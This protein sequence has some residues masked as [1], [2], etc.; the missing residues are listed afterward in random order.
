MYNKSKLEAKSKIN[1][2]DTYSV[3]VVTVAK[4][5]V[6]KTLEQIGTIM[7]SNDVSVVAEASG[8]VTGI[9]TK[10]GD[11]K[12][13]GS[14]IIQLDDELKYAAYLTAEV[15]YQ[16]AKNDFERYEYLYKEGTIPATR[17]DA[18]KLELQS[19]E[20]QYIF[21]KR[22]YTNTKITAPISGVITARN[23]DEGDYVNQGTVVANIVDISKLKVELN[24]AEKDAFKLKPGDEVEIFTDVYPGITYKGKIES[25]SSK[26]DA[27]HT[28]PLEITLPNNTKNPLK[29]GMFG[30]VSFTS[31]KNDKALLIPRAALVGSVRD[32]KVFVVENG[33]AKEKNI[34][35][36]NVYDDLLEVLQGLNPGEK[37]V[38]NGQ[39]NLKNNY[40]VKVIE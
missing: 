10:V 18:V 15:N 4:K 6:S 37:V 17:F 30:R 13:K 28:Y 1:V 26:G 3:N 11:N 23:V 16:K 29:A 39:N 22:E 12:S 40:A 7:G 34:L 33:I 32:A 27:S 25:I 2:I 21:A 14:V 24:V 9:F 19:A 38:V 20:S 8:K 31:I 35:I 5:E 36:G